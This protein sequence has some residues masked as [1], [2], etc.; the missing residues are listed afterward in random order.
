MNYEH[1]FFVALSI[2]TA[3]SLGLAGY[4]LRKILELSSRQETAE[5]LALE[6]KGENE[7]RHLEGKEERERRFQAARDEHDRAIAA[8]RAEQQLQNIQMNKELAKI[9]VVIMDLHRRFDA[10]MDGKH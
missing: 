3:I 10:V 8:V 4:G 7:R 1:G 6:R 9:E 2:L 5:A